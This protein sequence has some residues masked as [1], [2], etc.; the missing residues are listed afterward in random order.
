M[1]EPK[2]PRVGLTPTVDHCI[3]AARTSDYFQLLGV[4]VASWSFGFI[5]GK[6]A[7]FAMAG[8]MS[9]IGFTFGTM[10]ILQNT[11]NRF[12]GYRENSREIAKYGQED[13][14]AI[15]VSTPQSDY[16]KFN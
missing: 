6:P 15:A 7:R 2:Y 10:V 1:S 11:R 12:L 3:K 13:S 5:R 4:T 9:G 16:T 8:L 14:A